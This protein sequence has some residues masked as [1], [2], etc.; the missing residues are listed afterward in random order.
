MDIIDKD[1]SD[2]ISLTT[3]DSVEFYKPKSIYLN[4]VNVFDNTQLYSD[5]SLSSYIKSEWLT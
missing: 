5:T 2:H 3:Y 4:K 1:I